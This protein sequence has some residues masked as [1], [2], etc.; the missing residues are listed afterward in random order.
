MSQIFISY[1][2]A[3]SEGYVGRLRDQLVNI[4]GEELLFLDVDSIKPG[5]DFTQA[6]DEAVSSCSVLLAVIGPQWL[7]I[8][9][10]S[11]NRRLDDSN[12][13][14]RL[15]IASAPTTQYFSHSCACPA[16]HYARNRV[17]AR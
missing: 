3:D 2:R 16:R 13:F 8:R 17:L 10:S 4:A 1:R 11:G 5:Q 9:D 15:E 7:N 6:L 12:D 14:V